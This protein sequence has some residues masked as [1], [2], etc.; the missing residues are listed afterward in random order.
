MPNNV[1]L[2]KFSPLSNERI[3]E[4]I[5][6]S[7]TKPIKDW[8]VPISSKTKEVLEEEKYKILAEA[9]KDE[10]GNRKQVSKEFINENLDLIGE[11]LKDCRLI[12]TLNEKSEVNLGSY[13]IGAEGVS[14]INEYLATKPNNANAHEV[15]VVR[16]IDFYTDDMHSSKTSNIMMDKKGVH[17]VWV[18]KLSEDLSIAKENNEDLNK[19]YLVETFSSTGGNHFIAVTIRKEADENSPLVDFFDPSP[20]LLRGN[21]ETF[22]NSIAV[23]FAGQ[24]MV[25]ATLTKVFKEQGLEFNSEKYFNN[26]EPLQARGSGNCSVFSYEKAYT[27]A[28]LSR[29]EHEK[30]LRDHYRFDSPFG[31]KSEI[32][33]NLEA[34]KE[35]EDGKVHNPILNLP[36]QYMATS[37][38]GTNVKSYYDDGRMNEVNH[39]RKSGEEETVKERYDRYLDVDESGNLKINSLI[40]EKMLRQKY[41]HLFEIATSPQF[42]EMA[43]IE[44]SKTIP[45]VSVYANSA[46]FPEYNDSEIP[47]NEQ[48]KRLVKGYKVSEE[49]K[50]QGMQDVIGLNDIMPFP[51][52]IVSASYDEASNNCHATIYVSERLKQRLEIWARE[53]NFGINPQTENFDEKGFQFSHINSILRSREKV[54]LTIPVNEESFKKIA[55]TDKKR[56]ESTTPLP[57]M[58]VVNIDQVLTSQIEQGK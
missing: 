22:Q 6:R 53:N 54:T 50:K 29:E 55:D 25:D 43:E 52:K 46:Y 23:G 21:I 8:L 10:L 14:L 44:S 28:S 2:D 17:S 15:E 41:G 7:K 42:L 5:E 1:K 33:I 26:C 47:T 56:F 58:E 19:T 27:T 39:K 32:E 30:L 48:A 37:Q 16:N 24:I 20:G 38:F 35:S 51:T 49:E 36:P 57:R 9:T 18:A 13:V 34:V 31:G 40:L 45:Q 12:G 4:I 3:T 11:F